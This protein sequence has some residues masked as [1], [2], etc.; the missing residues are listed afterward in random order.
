MIML[1][2]WELGNIGSIYQ[3]DT[4]VYNYS[5]K[6]IYRYEYPLAAQI[7][8]DSDVFYQELTLHSQ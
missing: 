3:I 6:S 2:H 5:S 1:F 8:L 4:M 7:W